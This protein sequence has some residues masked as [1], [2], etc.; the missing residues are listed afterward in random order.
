MAQIL[1]ISST[2]GI[3]DWYT[4]PLSKFFYQLLIDT[5]LEPFIIRSMDQ[6]LGAVG[7]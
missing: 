7:F 1:E 5:L 2:S 3:C 4:T 6:K